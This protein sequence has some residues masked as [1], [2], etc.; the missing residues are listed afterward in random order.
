M[1][2][3]FFIFFSKLISAVDGR[4]RYVVEAVAFDLI[5]AFICYFSFCL[6]YFFQ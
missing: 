2:R 5:S 6:R 4:L 3:G 1:N